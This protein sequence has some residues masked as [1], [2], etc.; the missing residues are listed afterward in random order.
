M[1]LLNEERIFDI[2][3]LKKM[4][5]LE[6]KLQSRRPN[7]TLHLL[8]SIITAGIWIPIWFLMSINDAIERGR[9]ERRL[10]KLTSNMLKGE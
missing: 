4:D 7:H 8:L 1:L 5:Q 3:V 10:N 6:R 9:I 2:I